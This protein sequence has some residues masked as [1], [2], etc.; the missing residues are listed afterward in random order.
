MLPSGTFLPSGSGG[1]LLCILKAQVAG[2]SGRTPCY[3]KPKFSRDVYSS[4]A[5]W[6]EVCANTCFVASPTNVQKC[7]QTC[8]RNPNEVSKMSPHSLHHFL[9]IE[10]VLCNGHS[11]RPDV[12]A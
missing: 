8:P 2:A 6:R 5:R 1:F 4:F 10:P 12:W 11:D 7:V 3:L 9:Q